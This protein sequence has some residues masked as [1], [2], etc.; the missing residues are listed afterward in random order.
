[1][2]LFIGD[3]T[4]GSYH[5]HQ[6]RMENDK[7][8][9]TTMSTQLVLG[10]WDLRSS[11]KNLLVKLCF[12]L[13]SYGRHAFSVVAPELWNELP[14]DVKLTSTVEIFKRLLETPFYLSLHVYM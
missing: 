7:Q 12:N 8:I 6:S 3:K 4:E 9:Q 5:F 2:I 11:F 10:S 14:Q 1:M 13:N